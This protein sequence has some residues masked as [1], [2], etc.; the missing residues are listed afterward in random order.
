LTR[1]LKVGFVDQRGERAGGAERSLELLLRHLPAE[2]DA[3]VVLFEE[4]RFE[5]ELHDAGFRTSVVRLGKNSALSTRERPRLRALGELPS[6][7]VELARQLGAQRVDVVYTNS[8]K[9][10]VVGCFA[11]RLAGLPCVAHV[12][13]ILHGK[14]LAIV[15]TALS[16]GSQYRVAISARVAAS[17]ALP[18]TVVIDNPLD[19]DG[20]ADLPDRARA[21]HE[22]GIEDDLPV[23]AIVGR[24]NRWK[25][26]DRFLRA[27]AAVNQESPTRGLIVGA[28]VFRDE[29][30]L[31][32]LHALRRSLGLERMVRFVDW[33]DDP[34]RVYAATDIHVNASTEEPF[35]RN[36]IEAA[37]AGVPSVC[38]D[39][40]GV[41][42][43]MRG[44]T[45]IVVPARDEA[46]LARGMLRYSADGDALRAAGAAA[47]A[48]SRRFDARQHGSRVGDVIRRA[49]AAR[50]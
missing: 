31:P 35:G 41:S 42:E 18:N 34:R 1:R 14:A 19:L 11:A 40:S 30:F 49:Y 46:A 32:E 17:Y 48:W 27:L 15:R 8:V 26:Q 45:G 28:P 22:L 5:R 6:G 39:D 47:A 43:S 2:I 23:A 50:S 20:Y 25:G 33:V 4:G 9:A 13:D 36:V 12:R 21:R 16:V 7:I 10:H 3:H 29:D 38:F 37:A 44:H 24:I